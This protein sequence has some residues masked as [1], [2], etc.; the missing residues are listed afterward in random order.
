MTLDK[1]TLH[2]TVCK[3]THTCKHS[4]QNDLFRAWLLLFL[5]PQQQ[6]NT[7]QS[8]IFTVHIT[9]LSLFL[10]HTHTHSL[11]LSL[12]LSLTHTHTHTHSSFCSIPGYWTD[13]IKPMNFWQRWI[14]SVMGVNWECCQAR[15]SCLILG[16]KNHMALCVYTGVFVCVTSFCVFWCSNECLKTYTHCSWRLLRG[17]KRVRVCHL[18]LLTPSLCVLHII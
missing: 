14:R 1:K 5:M 4:E 15:W 8:V 7:N 16:E 17:R 2:Q 9:N 11:S 13:S 12:S 6:N 10:S 3:H 18:W